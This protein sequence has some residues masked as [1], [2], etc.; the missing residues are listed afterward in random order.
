MYTRQQLE[1][2]TR[3]ELKSIYGNQSTRISTLK[4]ID[5]ILTMQQGGEE[6]MND[7]ANNG[8]TV[9]SDTN[10][11]VDSGLTRE[12]DTDIKV[13]MQHPQKPKSPWDKKYK[14]II[15][16]TTQEGGKNNKAYL[17]VN[18]KAFRVPYD[19]EVTLPEPIVN[20]LKTTFYTI[21][22]PSEA[23]K[24]KGRPQKVLRFSF[25]VLGRVD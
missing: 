22:P 6:R 2:M 19:V 18:G 10:V 21:Y 20:M 14:V 15:N 11:N 8:L 5:K 17:C 7:F 23:G 13:D 16:K 1:G 3:T 25:S 24:P 12:P 4:L 9:D